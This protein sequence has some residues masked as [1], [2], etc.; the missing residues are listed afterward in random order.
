MSIA[1]AKAQV[2]EWKA[3]REDHERSSA[4]STLFQ[5][6]S[7]AEVVK[8]W[9]TGKNQQGRKL[10]R[11]EFGALVERWCEVFSAL[12]PDDD[13]AGA[14]EAL[15]A[16]PD[17]PEPD[18]ML[19]MGEVVRLTGISKSTIKR[20]VVDGRFPKPM[21]TSARRIGWPARDVKTW[22]DRLDDQRRAPRQ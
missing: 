17:D 19:R 20:M 14:E 21:R 6:V 7:A 3:Q 12:P 8:M 1:Q 22:I 16:V 9:E 13:D 11:F 18:T 5:H 10:T 15:E 2:A 4:M